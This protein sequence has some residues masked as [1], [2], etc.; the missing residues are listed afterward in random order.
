MTKSAQEVLNSCS[1]NIVN[2]N[3]LDLRLTWE[4]GWVL[5]ILLQQNIITVILQ[6]YKI[7]LWFILVNCKLNFCLVQYSNG[8]KQK[9]VSVFAFSLVIL[10]EWP[11]FLKVLFLWYFDGQGYLLKKIL[12]LSL[13]KRLHTCTH[14]YTH[15]PSH[16]YTEK[17]R[18]GLHWIRQLVICGTELA[19]YTFSAHMILKHNFQQRSTSSGG[20]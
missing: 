18:R 20:T 5:E 7:L 11:I 12:A 8:L 16:P 4:I 17:K 9:R 14:T 6:Y 3:I 10:V 2:S 13:E 19:W 1:I 15:T